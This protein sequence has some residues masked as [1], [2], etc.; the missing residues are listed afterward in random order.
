MR[1]AEI[2]KRL[3]PRGRPQYLQAFEHG[4]DLLDQHGVN[5]PRRLAHFLAQVLHETGGLTVL[6]EDMRYSAPR[7]LQI[8]GVGRHSAAVTAAEAAQ[9]A[10]RPE[11]LAERVY[12]IGNRRKAA[13]LGANR[14]KIITGARQQQPQEATA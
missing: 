14:R 5:T 11:A 10:G 6:R 13:E 2:V 1:A 3:C 12:G 8:F 4:D 9:L 7:I